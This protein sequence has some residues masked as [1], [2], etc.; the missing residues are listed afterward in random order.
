MAFRDE[1]KRDRSNQPILSVTK[2]SLLNDDPPRVLLFTSQLKL[3]RL[4]R[5]LEV[6]QLTFSQK[7]KRYPTLN[8]RLVL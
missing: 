7:E 3:A 6:V 4:D 5:L 2:T 8:D 1:V